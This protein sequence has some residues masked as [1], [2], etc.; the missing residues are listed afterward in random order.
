MYWNDIKKSS[1]DQESNRMEYFDRV[2]TYGS[3]WIKT[4]KERGKAIESHAHT[5]IERMYQ[6][7]GKEEVIE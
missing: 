6:H 1:A 2:S 3:T 4:G 5:V 7:L